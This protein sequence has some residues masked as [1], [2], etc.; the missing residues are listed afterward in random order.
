MSVRGTKC[1]KQVAC[2]KCGKPIKVG[3][4]RRRDTNCHQKCGNH[5]K[6]LKRKMRVRQ[7]VWA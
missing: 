5:V 6:Q 3:Q 4:W 2:T 7:G 1:K